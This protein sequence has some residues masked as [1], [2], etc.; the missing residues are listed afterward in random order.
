MSSLLDRI[1][2]RAIRATWTKK[3]LYSSSMGVVEKG[4]DGDWIAHV[5]VGA[6]LGRV[7]EEFDSAEVA[8]GVVERVWKREEEKRNGNGTVDRG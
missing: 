2:H 5:W 8:M 1:Q 4:L 6:K 7:K 3:E